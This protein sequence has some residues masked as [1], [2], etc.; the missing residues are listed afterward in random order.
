VTVDRNGTVMSV[1]HDACAVSGASNSS[2]EDVCDAFFEPTAAA[3]RQ[4]R[5]E[6]PVQGPIQFYVHVRYQPGAAPTITQS[7]ESYKAWAR[8]AQDSE[9]ARA[10]EKQAVEEF[11]REQERD[12]KERAAELIARSRELERAQRLSERGLL[13]ES[14]RARLQAELARAEA[15]IQND[16]PQRSDEQA[17]IAAQLA[18]EQLRAAQRQLEATR[19]RQS[20]DE[21]ARAEEERRLLEGKLHEIERQLAEAA[22]SFDRQAS[23]TTVNPTPTTPFDGSPQLKS[24]SGRAP[25]RVGSIP[26]MKPPVPTKRVKTEYSADAKQARVEGTVSVEVLVDERGHVAEARVLKSIPLLDKSAL[27]AAKQWEFTPT[28]MNGEPVPVLLMLEMHFTLK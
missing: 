27:D 1:A 10:D 12:L 2:R 19:A 3:I 22:L 24:P 11:L 4:W 5:Y 9:R 17:R 23:T 20:S 8:D 21:R 6:R 26:G 14:E 25:I 7:A 28:L 15:Q 13:A 16:R 18:A